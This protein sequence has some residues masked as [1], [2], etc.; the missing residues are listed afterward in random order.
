MDESNLLDKL[1]PRLLAV[2]KG[3]ARGLANKEI[4][5]RLGLTESTVKS[6]LSR[7]YVELGLA[8]RLQLALLVIAES[9]E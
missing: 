6:Y 1:T 4:G 3:V 9:A 5:A 8:S 2:A 7:I